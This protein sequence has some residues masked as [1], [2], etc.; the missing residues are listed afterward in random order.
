[1]A[2]LFLVGGFLDPE[3]SSDRDER[4][5]IE[6][7]HRLFDEHGLEGNARWVE[8]QTDKHRVGEI[9]RSVA[10]TRG[11][12]VQPALFEGFGLTVVEAMSSGLPVFATRYGGPLEIVVNGE[13]GFHIDPHHGDEASRQMVEFFKET[14]EDPE[15]WETI[16]DAAV[17]RVR[18]KYNWELHARKLLSLCRIYGFWKYITTLEREE[19]RRYLDMFYGLML[20]RHSRKMLLTRAGLDGGR[21]S[22]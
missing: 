1:M 7:M 15:R 10:D 17:A 20:R 3:D 22:P 9:Y 8:M 18:E 5:Q 13:T 11:A 12:F 14:T 19:T 16:S 2:N 6:G 4:D 21:A